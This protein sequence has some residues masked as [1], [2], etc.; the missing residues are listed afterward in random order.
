M[1]PVILGTNGITIVNLKKLIFRKDLA[2]IT[3]LIQDLDPTIVVRSIEG[4]ILIGPPAP[5]DLGII[6]AAGLPIQANGEVIGWVTGEDYAPAIAA[7]LSYLA[8]REWEKRTLAQELLGKYKEISLLFNLSEKVVDSFDVQDVAALMLDESCQLLNSSHG[9]VFIQPEGDAGLDCVATYG[10]VLPASSLAVLGEVILGQLAA[11]GRGAIINE[12]ATDSPC[13]LAAQNITSLVYMPLKSKEQLM[14]AIV[15][16]RQQPKPYTA[17]DAKILATLATQASGFIGAL[18]HE[19]K[20]K[21]SRQNDLIFRL[22]SQIR[23]S[24]ELPVTLTTAV[25]EIQSVLQLDRCLFLWCEW[26]EDRLME[27]FP[28]ESCAMP[29][30]ELAG[31][32]VVTEAKS[33]TLFSLIGHHSADVVGELGHTLARRSRVKLHDVAQDPKVELCTFLQRQGIGAFLAMPLRTRSRRIGVLCCAV[34][35]RSRKWRQDEVALLESVTN[36]L[37]IAIDQAELYAQSQIAT[38]AAEQKAQQLESALAQ[39]QAAQV[40]LIQSEKMSGLGQMV[41]GIA[42]E[43]NNPVNFIHGN[44]QHISH[45]LNDLLGLVQTYE[46]AYPAA[47]PLV[48]TKVADIDLEFLRQD[49]PKLLT[50]MQSGSNR[51]QGIVGSLRNFSRLDE[52]GYKLADVHEGLNSA[53]SMIDHRLQPNAQR[54]K[55]Q[56]TKRY[57]DLPLVP[58]YPGELNQVFLNLLNNAIDAI[59]EA[60]VKQQLVEPPTL[61][62]HTETLDQSTVLICITDNGVGIP[63]TIQMKL[64]DPFFTTKPVG[65]GTGLGLS[66]SYQ[67]IAE[68]HQGTLTCHSRPGEGAIFAITLPLQAAVAIERKALGAY[69]D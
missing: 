15:I 37:A 11:G 2:L 40:Q 55:I 29:L 62:V 24:L 41:A 21:E 34:D 48:Q 56:L 53:L 57:A 52:T 46:R 32:N 16:A 1:S 27:T 49:L 54:P 45:Y 13:Q 69:S 65:K 22:S 5:T 26:V 18:L 25:Q 6:A 35:G 7:F 14:G 66:I 3:D 17:E 68:Q 31:L 38:I 39:L 4:S 20:L 50:S 51:I 44:L 33:E 60:I 36:Q 9:A 42:H 30:G 47:N 63:E 10:P 28:T 64:F 19:R 58:C 8:A 12:L 43:I 61:S 23:D 59:E 67:I